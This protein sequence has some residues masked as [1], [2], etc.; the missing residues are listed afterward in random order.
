MTR[1]E[2]KDLTNFRR[3]VNRHK[4]AAI[5]VQECINN[6]PEDTEPEENNEQT[7]NNNQPT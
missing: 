2:R 4:Y 6:E 5:E 1:E 7:D 3:M